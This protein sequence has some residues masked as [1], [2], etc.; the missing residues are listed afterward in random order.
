MT[1][2]APAS[3]SRLPDPTVAGGLRFVVSESITEVESAWRLVHDSY[4]RIGLIEPN[5]AGVHTVPHAVHPDTAVIVGFEPGDQIV[6]TMSAYLDRPGG[7]P[8]DAVYADQLNA[9]RQQGAR[10]ME[11]GLFAD[12]RE[13]ITRTLSALMDLMRFTFYYGVHRRAT[14]IVIGVHP[15]HAGFYRR[16]LAFS[17]FGEEAGC[18]SVNG[19]PMVPLRLPI[20]TSLELDPLP[21]GLAYFKTN[22]VPGSAYEGRVSLQ[23]S[24]MVGTAIGAFLAG[25]LPSCV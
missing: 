24:A 7:L 25:R 15:H 12:R 22:P 2:L 3:R 23:L 5:S 20:A 18:P 14:D 11:V 19:S 16:V 8:L 1:S 10:L 6:S 13:K 17:D 9:M 4:A 21:K